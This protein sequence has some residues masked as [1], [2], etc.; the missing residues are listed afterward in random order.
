MVR[1]TVLGVVILNCA[2]HDIV[3]HEHLTLIID[4]RIYLTTFEVIDAELQQ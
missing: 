2:N 3:N 1:P 4:R